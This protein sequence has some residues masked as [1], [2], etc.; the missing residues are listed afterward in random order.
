MGSRLGMDYGYFGST[1]AWP[2][3]STITSVT[4]IVLL[5]GQQIGQ[6]ARALERFPFLCSYFFVH[7]NEGIK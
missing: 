5:F 7:Y 3:A 1:A 2:L 4:G 6:G